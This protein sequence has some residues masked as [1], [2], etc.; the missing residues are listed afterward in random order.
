MSSRSDAAQIT[1]TLLAFLLF[2]AR[3][4]NFDWAALLGHGSLAVFGSAAAI[5]FL[6][7]FELWHADSH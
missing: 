1:F 4:L 3:S 6:S 7:L 2:A 5:T